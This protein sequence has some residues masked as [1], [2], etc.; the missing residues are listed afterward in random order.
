MG[1]LLFLSIGTRP[2]ITFLVDVLSRFV[3]A[4]LDM[5]CSAAEPISRYLHGSSGP[6]TILGDDCEREKSRRD[7]V[8]ARWYIATVPGQ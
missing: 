6:K 1:S 4:P 3:E 2:D 7:L 5:H 8:P